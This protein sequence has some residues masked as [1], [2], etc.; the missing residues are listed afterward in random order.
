MPSPASLDSPTTGLMPPCDEKPIV[1]PDDNRSL[2]PDIVAD[3]IYVVPE[4]IADAVT[5]GLA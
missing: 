3:A 1:F 5:I 4:I 2:Y